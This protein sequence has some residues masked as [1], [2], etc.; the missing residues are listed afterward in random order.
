[1]TKNEIVARWMGEE[2]TVYWNY[3]TLHEAWAR[4]G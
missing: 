4:Q 3:N 1:M 2:V